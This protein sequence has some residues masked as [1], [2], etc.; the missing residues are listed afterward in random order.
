LSPSLPRSR[1]RRRP[2][3]VSVVILN[4][5]GLDETLECIAGLGALDW[6][7]DRLEVVVVDNCPGCDEV[8]AL[9]AAHPDVVVVASETNTGF[10]GGCNLGARHATGEVVAFLNN[11]ARPEPRWIAA[12]VA[13]LESDQSIACV[14]SKVLDWE[15]ATV[16][17]VDAALSY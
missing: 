7:A 1:G 5:H 13:A 6:P 10:A 17:F 14:A 11:D 16:D 2:G 15:G 3:V 4:F 8:A 9:R 12:G